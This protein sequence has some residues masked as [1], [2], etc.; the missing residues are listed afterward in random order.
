ML[1]RTAF[2]PES[3]GQ[4]FDTGT[5]ASARVL[6]VQ[7]DDA[8]VI[9]HVVDAPLA[10]GAVVHGRIDWP[11]RLDHMQQHTGQHILSAAFDHRFGVRT[12]S[13]HLGA[14]SSTIDL[15]REVTPAEIAEAEREANRIVWEARPVTVRF[16]TEEEAARLPLRKEPV[17]TG[18]LRLVDVDGLRPVGVRRHAR[19][20][21]RHDRGDRGGRAGSGSRARPG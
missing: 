18:L 11:R 9:H 6:D 15:A 13:F 4:P 12:T 5:L 3:G 14:E 20:A 19:P 7:D 1:D 2:Y 8:G 21:D 10:P 16:V 17:K